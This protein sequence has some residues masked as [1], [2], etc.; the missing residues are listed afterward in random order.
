MG[1]SIKSGAV[2]LALMAALSGLAGAETVI[3]KNGDRLT[4][5]D[6]SVA[7]GEVVLDTDYAETV[8]LDLGAVETIRFDQPVLVIFEDGSER[9]MSEL[10]AA[11]WPRIRKANP[12]APKV[13][14]FDG[15]AGYSIS[16][17]NSDTQDTTARIT[18]VRFIED[19]Y[20]IT[21][22][23]DYARGE[24][25]DED[26]GKDE[27]TAERGSLGLKADFFLIDSGY[28]FA[29]SRF[30]YDKM[31]DLDRR[32]NNGLGAGYELD[33]S[34][35]SFADL[36]LG[37]SYVDSRY[38]DDSREHGVYLLLGGEGR[39]DINEI[40]SLRG[41]AEYQ[42]SVDQFS[43]YL[44]NGELGLRVS[45]TTALYLQ[46]S[47]SDRYD[48]TPPPEVDPNDLS[49]IASLGVSL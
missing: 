26:T 44:F 47:L 33:R 6:C 22:R 42:P 37:A 5:T 41:R 4:G 40:L 34:G 39:L 11:E 32:I 30:S 24:R 29:A 23:G 7:E 9:E 19:L 14:S 12:P 16:R 8:K 18:L 45:L 21:G 31:K 25:K 2:T 10:S 43:D 49:L 20:R 15:S 17:G 35:E 28:L 36:N 38:D 1:R 3:L 46:L 48:S 27:R 13:W